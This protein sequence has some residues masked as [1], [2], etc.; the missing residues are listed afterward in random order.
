MFE[1]ARQEGI[2]LDIPKK[3][4]Y[5]FRM[6]LGP[7]LLDRVALLAML[8]NMID[9]GLKV[10]VLKDPRLG[11]FIIVA[12]WGAVHFILVRVFFWTYRELSMLV[13]MIIVSGYLIAKQK[14]FQENVRRWVERV[15]TSS[16]PKKLKALTYF[17]YFV[18]LWIFGMLVFLYYMIFQ[19]MVGDIT[20][21]TLLTTAVGTFIFIWIVR[22][23]LTACLEITKRRLN[24]S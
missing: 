13:G 23:Y 1:R 19:K 20:I 8:G 24:K 18:I 14:S 5:R 2:K 4:F 6:V 12:I 21:I 9:H 3:G 11:L 16:T 10:K 7:F 15:V 22:I 17:H